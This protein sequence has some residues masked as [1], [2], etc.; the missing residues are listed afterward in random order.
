MKRILIS[1]IAIIT[2]LFLAG[3][4]ESSYAGLIL[5]TTSAQNSLKMK[6]QST[7]DAETKSLLETSGEH[8]KM[9]NPLF[10]F[11]QDVY[12]VW[13]EALTNKL[14]MSFSDGIFLVGKNNKIYGLAPDYID[15]HKQNGEMLKFKELDEY[16]YEAALPLEKITE[17]DELK[18]LVL[19]MSS[20]MWW[21]WIDL[22]NVIH[23][24]S[25]LAKAIYVPIDKVEQDKNKKG[26]YYLHLDLEKAKDADIGNG[27]IFLGLFNFDNPKEKKDVFAKVIAQDYPCN[28][29]SNFII[30]WGGL[31]NDNHAQK[32]LAYKQ[33]IT[34]YTTGVY[35]GYHSTTTVLY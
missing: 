12:T 23:D 9:A 24:D 32:T 21:E 20:K 33:K 27:I 19:L 18:G 34:T 15:Q 30:P 31:F 26:I 35:G 29:G 4:N 2:I 28:W 3:C 14:R 17:P 11:E 25:N 13:P 8:Q 7:S 5:D 16:N 1:T 10:F 6:I 22:T